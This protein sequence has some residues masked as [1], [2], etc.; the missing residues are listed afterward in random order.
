MFV[1]RFFTLKGLGVVVPVLFQIGNAGMPTAC[2]LLAG[3]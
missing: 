2:A 1:I 3:G